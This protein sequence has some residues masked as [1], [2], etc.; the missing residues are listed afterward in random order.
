MKAPDARALIGEVARR[1]GI[2]LRPDDPAFALVTLNQLVLEQ[3]VERLD[4][5]IARAVSEFERNLERLQVAAGSAIGKEVRK[6]I[7]G[8]NGRPVRADNEIGSA[9][10]R[11]HE[12]ITGRI[13]FLVMASALFVLGLVLGRF[14]R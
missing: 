7:G 3:A 1:H 14:S 9:G 6:T 2:T 5:R 12:W 11:K 4:E 10:H 13:G 8:L